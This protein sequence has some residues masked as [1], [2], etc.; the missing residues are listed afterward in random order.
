MVRDQSKASSK[1]IRLKTKI[2]YFCISQN[3]TKAWDQELNQIIR[4]ERLN[5]YAKK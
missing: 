2:K 1:N 3:S 4:A 5:N